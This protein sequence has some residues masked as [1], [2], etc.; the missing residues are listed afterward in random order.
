MRRAAQGLL[1]ALL[2]VLWAGAAVATPPNVIL[3]AVYSE[4]TGRYAHGILG[5]A[6]EWGALVLTV[7]QCADCETRQIRK[8]TLRLPENRVFEDL[9]PRIV[10]DEF[11]M[12]YVMVVETDLELGARLALYTANGLSHATPFIGRSNRWLAPV[13]VADLDGDGVPEIAYVE[14][15][16]L[17]RE[18]KIWR[19]HEDRLEYLT[20]LSG[21]TNHRIG[22][23][24]ISGGIRDCGEGPE[25]IT[26]NA[27]WSGIM[28]TRFDGSR[29][30]T[31]RIAAFDGRAGFAAALD[32]KF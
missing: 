4:P 14:K 12:T 29:L 13:G 20:A 32:C 2:A 16:H 11:G 21:L 25:M 18:L 31:R 30:T 9:E 1:A 24:F 23:D 5:D 22:E 8:F 28:A 10:R 6:L 7:D 19:F 27:D 3:K 17:S 15:P 26:A